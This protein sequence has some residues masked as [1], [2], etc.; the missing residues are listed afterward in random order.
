MTDE[1]AFRAAILANPADDTVRL[2]FADWLQE[3]GDDDRAEFIRVQCRLAVLG[4]PHDPLDGPKDPWLEAR[5]RLAMD[6]PEV[7]ELWQQDKELLAGDYGRNWRHWCGPAINAVPPGMPYYDSVAFRRGFVSEV[8]FQTLADFQ[9]H[10]A[11]VFAAH[12]VERVVVSN[13]EPRPHPVDIDTDETDGWYLQRWDQELYPEPFR[14]QLLARG[15]ESF[16]IPPELFQAIPR[17]PRDVL[18]FNRWFPTRDAALDAFSHACV[19]WGRAQASL[20]AT[21]QE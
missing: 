7:V 3:Q 13:V 11:A 12:P 16:R 21:T 20:T 18:S 19:A 15:R 2:V 1:A 9:N 4:D 8:R 14:S 17:G 10:A 6:H 5:A